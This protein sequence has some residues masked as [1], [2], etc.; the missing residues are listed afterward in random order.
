MHEVYL[1]ASLINVVGTQ[2]RSPSLKIN[3]EDSQISEAQ[4]LLLTFLTPSL[5]PQLA[6]PQRLPKAGRLGVKPVGAN[7]ILQ[8]TITNHSRAAASVCI[9]TSTERISYTGPARDQQHTSTRPIPR[10]FPARGRQ[11]ISTGPTSFP[12]LT[13][14]SPPTVAE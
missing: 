14:T 11:L 7:R 3:V 1:W 6:S 2:P 13:S 12:G 4:I 9:S 10:T 5:Y 8:A